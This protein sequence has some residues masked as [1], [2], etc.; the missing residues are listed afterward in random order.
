MFQAELGVCQT[1]MNVYH[2]F[3]PISRTETVKCGMF[4]AICTSEKVLSDKF[5]VICRLEMVNCDKVLAICLQEMQNY[6]LFLVN[7]LKM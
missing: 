2:K 3:S 1:E 4:L 7:S 5:M 6:I